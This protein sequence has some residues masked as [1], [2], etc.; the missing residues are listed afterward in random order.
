ME[1]EKKEIRG[2]RRS[3]R[4]RI[5]FGVCGGLA[6]Y[7]ELD[8]IIF[9]VIFVALS[10]GSGWGI[11]LYLLLSVIIP[12]AN[13]VSPN[14]SEEMDLRKRI[15]GLVAE[16]RDRSLSRSRNSWLGWTLVSLGIILLLDQI[17]PRGFFNWRF[18]WAVVIIAMGFFI[19]TRNQEEEKNTKN[20]EK[21]ISQE[22]ERQ[23]AKKAGMARIFFGFILL[24]IGFAFLTENLGFIPGF[25]VNLSY[26]FR[27]WPVFIIVCGLSLLSKGSRTGS[28]LS[29][30]IIFILITLLTI[31]LF[32]PDP[33]WFRFWN[34]VSQ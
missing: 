20:E 13:P 7:F 32:F 31:S 6:E 34:L 23:Y 3:D 8:P 18:L 15:D 17:L 21:P 11:L 4:N 30:I 5:L 9:R 14:A 10:L 12:K 16:L 27:F 19:L 28:I 2:L 24:L 26:I 22:E 1:Q 29:F 25:K 33:D